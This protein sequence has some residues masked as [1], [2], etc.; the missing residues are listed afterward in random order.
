MIP[1]LINNALI[2]NEGHSFLGSVLI[3]GERIKRVFCG[4]VS[5]EILNSCKLVDASG[6]WLLPGV[7]DDHVHFRDPGLTHKADF[8]SESKAALAGGVTSIMDMPNTIPQTTSIQA[9]K[10]KMVMA[11]EKSF[12]NYAFYLGTTNDNLLE[13]EKA[14]FSQVCGVKVFM[15]SSTGNMLVDRQA[16]LEHIFKSVPAIVA[17]HAE[18]EAI[19]KANKVKYTEESGGD[20]PLKFH[21]LIRSS[22]ACYAS[23]ARAVELASRLG[24]RLHILHI[25][26]AKELLLL[27]NK[28]IAEKKITAEVCIPHLWFDSDDYEH[29]GNSIKC[30]PALKTLRDRDALREA[31]ATNFL[32]VIATDHAPH[33]WSEK[34]GNCLTAASGIPSVQFSLPLMLEL[35]LNGVFNIEKVVEKMCHAPA[36]LFHINERGYIRE[37]YYADIVLVDPNKSWTLSGKQILSKCGWSPYENQNFHTSV[38]Q[39]YLNGKLVY[40]NNKPLNSKAAKALTFNNN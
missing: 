39:T 3:D 32:D 22:E 15:G 21:T 10:E 1:L 31:V 20:L 9:W 8:T 28:P 29:Y 38:Y 6:K 36:D 17:V 27:E 5:E 2:V 33:L 26:T 11:S 13:L 18:S 4:P 30:N 23:S 25:S 37:G 7:I 19:I 12:V 16:V 14:D 35:T 34:Q 24:T 40:Q